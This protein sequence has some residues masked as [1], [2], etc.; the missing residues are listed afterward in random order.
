MQSH[1]I[2][3]SSVSR[4]PVGCLFTRLC[5]HVSVEPAAVRSRLAVR[6][7]AT[8]SSKTSLPLCDHA[9]TRRRVRGRLQSLGAGDFPTKETAG[10]RAK[11]TENRAREKIES[12]KS[13]RD[14]QGQSQRPQKV[15]WKIG[16]PQGQKGTLLPDLWPGKLSN[17]GVKTPSMHRRTG[18]SCGTLPS[19]H[20]YVKL[21][22]CFMKPVAGA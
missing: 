21:S 17:L 5:V 19:S 4:T 16:R 11:E 1:R 10:E 9:V 3:I 13:R 12:E 6:A 2:S 15:I 8:R 18:N 14:S 20:V 7:L 22:P